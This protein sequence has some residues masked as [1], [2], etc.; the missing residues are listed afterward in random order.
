MKENSTAR[1]AR[2]P[3]CGEVYYAHG[4][5]SRTDNKTLICPD[6]GIRESLASIGCTPDEQEHILELIHA[7]NERR[8]GE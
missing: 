2:C 8:P 6:C 3:L 4:A 5:I 7:F 1:V